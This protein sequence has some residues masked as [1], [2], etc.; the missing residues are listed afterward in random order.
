M[1]VRAA[2][3]LVL[4][5]TAVGIKTLNRSWIRVMIIE[6]LNFHGHSR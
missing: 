6:T 5:E 1:I 4:P 2:P 3:V